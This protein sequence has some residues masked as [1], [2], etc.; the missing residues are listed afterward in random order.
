MAKTIEY[1]PKVTN[2]KTIYCD[3]SPDDYAWLTLEL[4]RWQCLVN[5]LDQVNDPDSMAIR[6]QWWHRQTNKITKGQEGKNSPASF[7]SGIINNLWFKATPQRDFTYTQLVDC[8]WI[9][10]VMSQ[11]FDD[12]DSITIRRKLFE[13]E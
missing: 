4:V 10:T 1:T 3:L 8:E 12:V 6:D 7:V 13:F 2:A 9:S 11:L 5:H